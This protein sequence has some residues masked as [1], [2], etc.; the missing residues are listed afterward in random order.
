MTCLRQSWNRSGVGRSRAASSL[1]EAAAVG[2]GDALPDRAA[3]AAD[4]PVRQI[5]AQAP[6]R[7]RRPLQVAFDL[8][9]LER[10]AD[11]PLRRR[12]PD[13]QA[14]RQLRLQP[15]PEHAEGVRLDGEIAR[16]RQQPARVAQTAVVA[17]GLAPGPLA[18][19]RQRRAR[20]LEPGPHLVHPLLLVALPIARHADGAAELLAH[21][22]AHRLDDLLL[23]LDPVAHASICI[24]DGRRVQHR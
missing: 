12:Q 8:F 9:G 17:L 16:P 15:R 23:L 21:D 18:D 20:A 3:T 19:Q 14:R 13:Q 6:Q 22:P 10:A 5:A 11:L 7:A 4:A 1:R 24:A 2:P